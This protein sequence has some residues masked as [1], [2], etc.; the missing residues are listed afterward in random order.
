MFGLEY[1]LN[2]RTLSD[3]PPSIPFPTIPRR[4]LIPTVLLIFAIVSLSSLRYTGSHRNALRYFSG[5]SEASGGD[6]TSG[7][8]VSEENVKDVYNSTL[9]V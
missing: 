8:K 1:L 7:V 5:Q 3:M 6:T 2:R 9:G 4:L